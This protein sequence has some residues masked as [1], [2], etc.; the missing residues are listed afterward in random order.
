ML[1]AEGYTVLTAED[2]VRGLESARQHLPDVITLDVVMPGGMDGWEVLRELK[3]SPRTQSIPV[4]MVSVM[5]EQENGLTLDVEDYLVKPIDVNRLSRVIQRVSGQSPQR[6][7]LLVDDDSSSL[8]AMSRILEEAGWQTIVA[9]NGVEALEMLSKTRPAA[10]ILDLI[11]PEMDGF[12]FL[13]KREQDATLRSIP[14][15]VMSGKNPTS[16]EREFLQQR[17]TAVLQ[18]GRHAATDLVSQ[19]NVRVRQRRDG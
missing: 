7:L 14:V 15:I 3:E 1:E 12:E 5:A 13:E 10:I 9:H 4:I 2:G 17:A 6:N 18:K 19:V 16:T 11:M 8:E